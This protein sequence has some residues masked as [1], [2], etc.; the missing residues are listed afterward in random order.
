VENIYDNLSKFQLRSLIDS[1]EV[2][3]E[4]EPDPKFKSLAGK[5]FDEIERHLTK[6][7]INISE[8]G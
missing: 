2:I 5:K 1:W 6:K 7:G 8:E 3:S 4:M